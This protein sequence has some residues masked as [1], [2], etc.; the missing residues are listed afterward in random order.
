MGPEIYPGLA[1]GF[2]QRQG[3]RA[4]PPNLSYLFS[5]PS[6]RPWIV[7]GE[8]QVTDLYCLTEVRSSRLVTIKNVGHKVPGVVNYLA[9]NMA[10]A[11]RLATSDGLAKLFGAERGHMGLFA[12][13]G[14]GGV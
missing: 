6:F 3:I 7:S 2:F 1:Q 11:S 8:R 9:G 14:V 12:F 5:D 13:R 4:T 10:R